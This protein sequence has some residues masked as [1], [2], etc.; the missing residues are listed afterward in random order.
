MGWWCGIVSVFL[1]GVGFFAIDHGGDTGPGGPIGVLVNEVTTTHGR[2][3]VGNL[4]G[5]IGALLLIWFAAAL[6][7]RLAREGD[8]GSMIG[9]AAFGFALLMSAGGLAH[10]AFRLAETT[11]DATTLT[12]AMRPLAILETHV[13]DAHWWGMIGLVV[14]I[15]IGGFVVGFIPKPLAAL[16]VFLSIIALALSP[17]SHGAAAVSLQPWLF[18]VC[19]LL[20]LRSRRFDPTTM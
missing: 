12:Q 20:L 13:T 2:I 18:A 16:G 8:T 11:V 4:V 15:C 14:A 10:A 3:V 9:L 6:H 19:V 5:V 17:T 1:I 7:M